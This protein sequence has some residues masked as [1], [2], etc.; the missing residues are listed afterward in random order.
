MTFPLQGADSECGEPG[1]IE[2]DSHRRKQEPADESFLLLRLGAVV[3]HCL[4]DSA[5]G[6]QTRCHSN[7]NSGNRTFSLYHHVRRLRINHVKATMHQL[8]PKKHP[9]Q[10]SS[11]MNQ[12]M[13]LLDPELSSRENTSTHFSLK[14]CSRQFKRTV[15]HM[16]CR[17]RMA[18]VVIGERERREGGNLTNQISVSLQIASV[19]FLLYAQHRPDLCSR[20][21]HKHIK[22]KNTAYT[23]PEPN[24][25]LVNSLN[26]RLCSL[27]RTLKLEVWT[28]GTK[29]YVT[30]LLFD[31]SNL[32]Q[33][34]SGSILYIIFIHWNYKRCAI[35]LHHYWTWNDL[36]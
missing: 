30:C 32:P 34:P 16:T 14:I 15:G 33:V 18:G 23:Q 4:A 7:T 35:S 11:V 2:I 5:G 25:D 12:T 21:Q 24:C 3:L 8:C 6:G 13:Q 27:L 28:T 26:D 36:Y 29:S 20:Q 22:Q 9:E 1:M 10:F 17:S 31:T 19:H